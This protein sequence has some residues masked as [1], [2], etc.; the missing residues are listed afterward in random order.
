VVVFDSLYTPDR[1]A[2]AEIQTRPLKDGSQHAVLKIYYTPDQ[3]AA[4]LAPFGPV[5]HAGSTGQFFVVGELV[6]RN[7]E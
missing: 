1:A 2:R 5:R 6:T 3:L 4:A 7:E